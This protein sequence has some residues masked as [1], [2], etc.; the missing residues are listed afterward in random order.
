M[1]CVHGKA[2]EGSEV[3]VFFCHRTYFCVLSQLLIV[4]AI[5]ILS[6]PCQFSV[7]LLLS[8]DSFWSFIGHDVGHCIG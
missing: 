6:L 2:T 7:V 3:L 1:V 4:L 8:P 5:N